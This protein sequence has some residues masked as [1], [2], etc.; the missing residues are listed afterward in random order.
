M[1]LALQS[2]GVCKAGLMAILKRK[3][4]ESKELDRNTPHGSQL[5]SLGEFLVDL[6]AWWDGGYLLFLRFSCAH[7]FEG[8]CKMAGWVWLVSNE[9]GLNWRVAPC[10]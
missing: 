7:V 8:E 3:A 9:L 2:D 6:F 4:K 10:F 5:R 1:G